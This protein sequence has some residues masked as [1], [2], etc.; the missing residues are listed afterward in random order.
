LATARHLREVRPVKEVLI[1][2]LE[3]VVGHPEPLLDRRARIGRD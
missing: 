2:D 3:C 1:P